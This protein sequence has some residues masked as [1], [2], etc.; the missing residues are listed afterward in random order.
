[1]LDDSQL[2]RALHPGALGL[3]SGLLGIALHDK[4]SAVGCHFSKAVPF[5][6]QSPPE[7]PRSCCQGYLFPFSDLSC[8]V[9]SIRIQ[10]DG[11]C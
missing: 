11:A 4:V 5:K 8:S 2:P 1:M 7:P 3:P 9:A 10:K 6:D